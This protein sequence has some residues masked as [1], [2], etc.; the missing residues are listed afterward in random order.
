M[1]KRKGDFRKE[2]RTEMRGGTGTVKFERMWER[3]TEMKS[4]ARLFSKLILEPGVSIGWHVH[5]NEDE[6]YYI[7]SGTAETD[8][9]GVKRILQAGDS[10][11]TRSGE[12]HSITALGSEKLELIATIISY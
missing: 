6:I 10:T 8:D 4:K 12:G 1:I 2:T 11:L 3:D 5:E 9:N 7:L